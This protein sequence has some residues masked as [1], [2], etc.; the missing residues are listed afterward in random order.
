MDFATMICQGRLTDDPEVG[1]LDSG[2]PYMRFTVASNRRIRK[3]EEKTSFIPVSVFGNKVA[4]CEEFLHKGKE[5]HIEG[6]FETDSYTDKQG[7]NRKGFSVVAEK[8]VF[9]K[10][11][12]DVDPKGPSD[13]DMA[14]P[15]RSFA[16]KPT[17]TSPTQR[18]KDRVSSVMRKGKGRN[19]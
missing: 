1:T 14:P 4:V 8:V 3:G 5:V 16:A 15:T 2:T 11:A 18:A 17:T 6:N 13:E 19:F 9:G 12:R 7:V 10:S